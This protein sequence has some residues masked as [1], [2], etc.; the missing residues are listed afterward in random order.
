VG[1]DCGAALGGAVDWSKLYDQLI[2]ATEFWASLFGALVG[3]SIALCIQL[4]VFWQAG[5]ER[6]QRALEEQEAVAYMLFEK[7]RVIDT[8]LQ[9]FHQHALAARSKLEEMPGAE[10]WNALLPLGNFPPPVELTSLE[11]AMLIRHGDWRLY[12]KITTIVAV[13]GADRDAF[14]T[15]SDYR[16]SLSCQLPSVIE[17]TRGLV[18]LTREEYMKVAPQMASA[19]TLADAI[20]QSSARHAQEARDAALAFNA[21]LKKLVGRSFAMQ[22]RQ[23]GEEWPED[24]GRD[25]RD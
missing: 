1:Q 12:D 15:Y 11:I 5:R 14:V 2:E 16:H 4:L 21:A 25:A 3:G 13:Y 10:S 18:E 8:G 6:K 19:R 20:M 9:G 17:G 24:D 23:P 7:L 22:F